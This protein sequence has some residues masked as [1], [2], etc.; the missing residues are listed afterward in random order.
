VKRHNR[1]YYRKNREVLLAYQIEYREKNREKVRNYFRV[2]KRRRRSA[3]GEISTEQWDTLVNFYCSDGR[4]IAC[5]K[6]F[7][8]AWRDRLSLDHIVPLSRGGTHWPEN[9]QPICCSCNSSKGNREI[10]D[11]RYDEGKFARS[12]M[13]Q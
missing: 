5:G 4:C 8:E 9:V 2:I 12:L 7:G 10:V 13:C 11:Y 3:E 6:L 1:E